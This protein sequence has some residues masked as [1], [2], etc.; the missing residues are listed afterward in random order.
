MKPSLFL[1]LKAACWLMVL[2]WLLSFAATAQT[3]SDSFLLQLGTY[4]GTL[5]WEQSADKEHW[6]NVVNGERSGI[7]VRPAAT[8][9]YR[10]RI[11]EPGCN[12]LYS[13]TKAVVIDGRFAIGATEIKGQL[14][15]PA[16]TI[17]STG[18][19]VSTILQSTAIN[20]DHS[21]SLL[22]TDT[23]SAQLLIATNSQHEVMM[24]SYHWDDQQPYDISAASTA[25]ALLMT[26]PFLKPVATDAR[27]QLIASYRADADFPSLVSYIEQKVKNNESI[28]NDP[29]NGLAALI[30]RIVQKGYNAG[31]REAMTT[32]MAAGEEVTVTTSGTKL[33]LNNQATF[34]YC[35]G[36]YEKGKTT[37]LKIFS[38]SGTTLDQHII[39]KHLFE[40]FV[41]TASLN[42]S[43]DLKEYAATS[44]NYVIRLRNGY[45][46]DH[47]PEDDNARYQN[48]MQVSLMLISTLMP[49]IMALAGK[50]DCTRSTIAAVVN[51]TM[52]AYSFSAEPA[53]VNLL[54]I[55]SQSMTDETTIFQHCTNDKVR[56]Y[57]ALSFKYFKYLAQ[58]ISLYPTL[59]FQAKWLLGTSAID[60]CKFLKNDVE[61]MNCFNLEPLTTIPIQ[62]YSCD[63]MSLKIK[64]VEDKNYYP[65]QGNPVANLDFVWLTQKGTAVF[66][67]AG[68]INF[69]GK[70]NANGEATIP[71]LLPPIPSQNTAS[72]LYY[73]NT[74]LVTA[75]TFTTNAVTPRPELLKSGD[76]QTGVENTIL[77]TPLT[78]TIRD[79]YDGTPMKVSRFT[80]Q[81]QVTG[82]G[83]VEI[84]P[85]TSNP[86][87][88]SWKWQLGPATGTQSVTF[89]FKSNTCDWGPLSTTFT[90]VVPAL[91][92]VTTTAISKIGRNSAESGGNVTSDGGSSVTERG[93]CW[94][95]T[96]DKPTLDDSYTR[97]GT[98]RG[99]FTSPF[100]LL[101]VA[102]TYYVRAYA[103]NARGTAYGNTVT[104]KTRSWAAGDTAFGGIVAYVDPSGIHGIV[105]APFDQSKGTGWHSSISQYAFVGGLKADVGSGPENTKRILNV[106]GSQAFAAY[107]C[108][109]LILN[110]YDDWF[111]PSSGEIALFCTRL[112]SPVNGWYWTST[113]HEAGGYT[114]L[115]ADGLYQPTCEISQALDRPTFYAVRAARK[116]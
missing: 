94:S 17:N 115:W 99:I 87:A 97:N 32:K 89:T 84:D 108:D 88:G 26:Y 60:H 29:A 47:T 42:V 38:L 50:D 12:T 15:L 64:A 92:V 22:Q 24:L 101:D 40:L 55:L 104:F 13:D 98:G 52:N 16:N 35:G 18:W 49:D 106:W 11:A 46:Y 110:G 102:T 56:D 51:Q 63:T 62:A 57:L 96:A 72:A 107:A 82:G 77:N 105:F 6:S 116:F 79:N 76:L 70:T 53:K 27:E 65:Y 109:T 81:A 58:A 69:A 48:V 33:L 91:P 44:G 39:P 68:S 9:Y 78:I 83:T 67:P 43:A 21:F 20:A 30:T 59:E 14:T 54:E 75:T 34:N 73:H 103:T 5:Q 28:Y 2:S 31:I 61:I 114:Y 66:L 8:T 37:P 100:A 80:V 7:R 45:A 1:F 74:T 113:A 23:S 41:T 112:T 19:E 95:T 36:I 93:V 86:L 71:W 25:L 4:R 85:A 10:A 90:A 3:S 111:L